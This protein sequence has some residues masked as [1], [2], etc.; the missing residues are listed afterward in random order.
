MGKVNLGND[1]SKK[2][3]LSVDTSDAAQRKE[4]LEEQEELTEMIG[5]KLERA[6]FD[7]VWIMIRGATRRPTSNVLNVLGQLVECRM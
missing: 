7:G 2:Y 6:D 5:Q 4:T 3:N 1:D